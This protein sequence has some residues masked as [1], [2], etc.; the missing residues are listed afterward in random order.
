MEMK[1]DEYKDEKLLVAALRLD[2]HEAFVRI[3][4]H[5]YPNLVL[6]ASQFIPDRLACEDIV[7]NIFIKI[8][9]ERKELK[10]KTSLR[11]FLITL[12]QNMCLDHIRHNKVKSRYASELHETILSLSPEE[13]MFYSELNKAFDDALSRMNPTLRETLLLSRHEKLKYSEIAERLGVSRRTVEDRVSKAMKFLRDNLKDYIYLI[14]I[15]I[16]LKELL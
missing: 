15:T 6:F 9:S 8:W 14:P 3:F 12:V 16:L 4:R 7:Q 1:S 2:S 13:H 5:Y 10:I 11:S